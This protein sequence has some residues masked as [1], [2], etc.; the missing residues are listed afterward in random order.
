ML[1]L[2]RIVAFCAVFIAVAGCH[3]TTGTEPSAVQ[4]VMSRPV[5]FADY[6]RPGRTYLS[7]S[8]AHGFQVNYLGNGRAWLWYPGNA[9]VVPEEWKKDVVA[10]Q[11]ALCWRHPANSYNPVT[12]TPGGGYACESLSLARRTIVAA[13]D[14]D[15]FNLQSG[16]VPYRLQRC[17]APAEFGHGPPPARCR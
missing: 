10:G 1:I 17:K 16:A 4:E 14:G 11:Q 3:A 5:T 13:L 7:F 2:P 9:A 12:R 6:P 15:P 8:S